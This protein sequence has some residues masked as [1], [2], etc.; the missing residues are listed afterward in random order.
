MTDFWQAVV[1]KVI[2]NLLCLG[3]LGIILLPIVLLVVLVRR[4]DQ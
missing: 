2:A 1:V 4:F 3:G